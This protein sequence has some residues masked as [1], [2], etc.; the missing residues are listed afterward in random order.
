[1]AIVLPRIRSQGQ[2]RWR[3]DQGHRSKGLF[4][5]VPSDDGVERK[6][7][8]LVPIDQGI[9]FLFKKNGVELI[10]GWARIPADGQVQV[11]DDIYEAKNILIA[12]GSEPTPL[13]GIEI[14]EKDVLSSYDDCQA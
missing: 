12:T 11:G 4:I 8:R 5:D 3:S 1:M 6:D 2:D 10:E 14:D 9:G 13:N 7:R